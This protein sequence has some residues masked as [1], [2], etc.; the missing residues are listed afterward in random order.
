MQNTCKICGTSTTLIHQEKFH[1]DYHS[2]P[3]CEL[4]SKDEAF[5]LSSSEELEIYNIHNN[6]IEDP[7]YVA[8][9]KKFLESAI[10]PFT[11]SAL[12]MSPSQ[13]LKKR[14]FDFGSGPSPVL[15]Q[16]LERDYGV[17]MDIYDLFYSPEK[18]YVG[19][20]YNLITST[21]VVEHLKNPLP[22][23]QLLKELLEEDGIL[24]IMTWFH[25]NDATHFKNWH[26]MRDETHISFYTPKTMAYIAD[27]VGLQVIYSDNYRYTTFTKK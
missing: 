16:I 19:K 4:I 20:K 3:G 13:P 22:T 26:Y 15:A 14:G 11:S 6:S 18:V 17:D 25:K 27:C 21:E 2:C 12:E 9:F 10:F 23:F 5:I 7:R 8:Y 1:I 24:G